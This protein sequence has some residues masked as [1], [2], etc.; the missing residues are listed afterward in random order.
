MSDKIYMSK[1]NVLCSGKDTFG[2]Q[3]SMQHTAAI[4]LLIW[5]GDIF[6]PWIDMTL[7]LWIRLDSRCLCYHTLFP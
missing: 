6:S 2:F 7:H 5:T 3:L 4:F 1:V